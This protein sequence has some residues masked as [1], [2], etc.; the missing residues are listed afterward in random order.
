MQYQGERVYYKNNP[1]TCLKVN[2]YKINGENHV[3]FINYSVFYSS[4]ISYYNGFL[5]M[6]VYQ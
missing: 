2:K 4:F 5:H 3:L 6:N 1:P